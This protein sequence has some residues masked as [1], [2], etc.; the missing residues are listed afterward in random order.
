MKRNVVKS[1][2]I[3]LILTSLFIVLSPKQVYAAPDAPKFSIE[4]IFN[5]LKEF[6][7]QGSSEEQLQMGTEI[8]SEIQPIINAIYWVGVAI[9]IGASMFLGIQ[10]FQA[11]GD[12]KAKAAL[13]SKLVGFLISSVVLLS[14]YPIWNYLIKILSSVI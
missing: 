4:S 5:S 12:P 3:V 14:A 13:Q 1:I 9:V 6:L 7:A 10:Y 8:S 11:T 2:I